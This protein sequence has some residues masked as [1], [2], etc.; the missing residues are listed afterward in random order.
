MADIS[1]R[2]LRGARDQNR[3]CVRKQGNNEKGKALTNREFP[4]LSSALHTV[5]MQIGTLFAIEMARK[6]FSSYPDLTLYYNI[7][8]PK[9]KFSIQKTFSKI[10]CN[11]NYNICHNNFQLIL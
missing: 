10:V 5:G 7:V 2:E 3:T 6:K 11:Y 8:I 4:G 1:S 9:F